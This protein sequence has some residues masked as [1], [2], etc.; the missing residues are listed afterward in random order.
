MFDFQTRDAEDAKSRVFAGLAGVAVLSI[1]IGCALFANHRYA[2]GVMQ[3]VS[4][5][6]YGL[7]GLSIRRGNLRK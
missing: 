4:G 5:M 3:I 7:W 2:W 1:P 6:A